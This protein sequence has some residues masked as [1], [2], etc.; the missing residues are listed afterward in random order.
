MKKYFVTGLVILLPLTLTFFIV[1]FF[2]NLLTE[3][4]VGFV[5]PLLARLG[6]DTSGFSLLNSK[7]V[8]FFI[9]EILVLIALFFFTVTLGMVARWFFFH[10]IIRLWDKLMHKIPFIRV[11]YKT[12]KDVIQTILTNDTKSFKQVVIAP[13]PNKGSSSIGLVTRENVTGIPG[14]D[15]ELVTVFI[16]TTPNPTSGY[17]ILYPKEALTYMDMKVEEALKYVISCGVIGSETFHPKIEIPS[18]TLTDTLPKE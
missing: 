13:F 15:K 7:E 14:M 12:T 3:P 18:T 2:V 16:P 10:T 17:L 1:A 4:F 6:L 9:S 11:V 5:Q 8:Q